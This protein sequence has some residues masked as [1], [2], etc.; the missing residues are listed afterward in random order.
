V[1]R[2]TVERLMAAAGL[3]GVRRGRR[4]KTTIAD[5]LL[6]RPA[7]LVDRH[8]SA[9]APNRLWV[10][11]LTYA[12]THSGFVYVASVVDVFSR[13]VVG[14]R[15]SPRCARTS[16]STRSRWPSTRGRSSL[17]TASSTTRIA[18][19]LSIRYTERLATAG[20]EGSVGS[21]GDSY[22]CARGELQRALQVRVDLPRR[23]LE[24]A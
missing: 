17:V 8:F 13:F 5:E 18:G 11:D 16:P 21:K 3:A 20:I 15:S 6:A 14:C 7:D 9:S 12:K 10:A 4:W 23:T 24:G 1:A 22:D 19:F 2:C